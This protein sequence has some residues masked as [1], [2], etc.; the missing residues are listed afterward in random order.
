VA[1]CREAAA[2]GT[3]RCH[4]LSPEELSAAAA[5]A[6]LL[7]NATSAG[8][9]GVKVPSLPVDIVTARH[10]VMDLVYGQ[11]PTAFVAEAAE[12]GAR[13]MDGREMLLQ[14]AVVSYELWTGRT[15][16]ID[17]MRDALLRS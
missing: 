14:Q 2:W 15:A 16:P 17:V 4:P 7:V 3:T 8:L 5:D 10:V 9:G 13:A 6:E 1:L 11:G 12:R